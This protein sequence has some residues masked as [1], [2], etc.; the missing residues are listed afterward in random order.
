MKQ[1]KTAQL[2]RV[3]LINESERKTTKNTAL[4]DKIKQSYIRILKT[5]FKL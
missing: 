3:S 4:D 1:K 5:K 2:R